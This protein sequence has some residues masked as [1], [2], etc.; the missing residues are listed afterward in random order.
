MVPRGT[1]SLL[2]GFRGET[3]VG[4]HAGRRPKSAPAADFRHTSVLS[5]LHTGARML[6]HQGEVQGAEVTLAP[7]AAQRLLVGT[8][9]GELADSVTDPAEVLGRRFRH[10][11]EALGA[12]PSWRARF[13][14]LDRT[15][16]RW[17]SDAD[18]S[19]APA[20]AVLHAWEILTRTSGTVSIQEVATRT[21]WGVRHLETRFREQIGLA[22]KR[23]ARVLRLNRSIWMLSTGRG[24][25]DTAL[26]CGLYDQSH[27]IREFKAMT[28]MPPGRFL[29]TRC[30]SSFWL[31]G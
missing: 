21:G 5:G 6:G 30:Q 24:Q 2:I 20:P 26:A 17:T 28:G 22:P 14:L 1:V 15:L 3:R 7:W 23:L 11:C 19:R 9:L 8:T 29:A 12:L 25:A 27:L 4:G 13:A 31:A 18:P 16:L 10:L